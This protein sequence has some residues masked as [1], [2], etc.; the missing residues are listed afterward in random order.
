MA[1]GHGG[2]RAGSGRKPKALAEKL[3]DGNP[4]KRR[5]V[6]VNLPTDNADSVPRKCPKELREFAH[7]AKDD[8]SIQKVYEQTV[9]WLEGAK[10]LHLINPALINEYAI[11]KNRWYECEWLV[12]REIIFDDL[13]TNPMINES[14]KY[15][16]AANE[17]WDRIWAIVAQNSSTYYGDKPKDDIMHNLIFSKLQ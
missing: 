10:C 17:V 1:N 15:F 5:P 11:L 14:M 6:V 16:K 9:E 3:L 12:A 13:T 4:S 7:Y 2:K 8:F